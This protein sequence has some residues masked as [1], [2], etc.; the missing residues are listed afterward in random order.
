[1]RVL[2]DTFVVIMN[3]NGDGSFGA[4]LADDVLIELAL[5]FRRFGDVEARGAAAFPV[6]LVGEFL[7][8]DAFA[9][10]DATV[11]DVNAGTGNEFAHFAVGFS[12]EAAHRQVGRGARHEFLIL[13][14]KC[15]V[16]RDAPCR[17]GVSRRPGRIGASRRDT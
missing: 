12:T 15:F 3:R 14:H 4:F 9:N 7:I 2:L 1:M 16:G 13:I 5:N 17:F 11:A 8:E 6:V 10:D